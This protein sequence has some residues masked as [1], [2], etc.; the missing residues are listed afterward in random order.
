MLVSDRPLGMGARGSTPD[1]STEGWSDL[2]SLLT[3]HHFIGL[4]HVPQAKKAPNII[5]SPRKGGF[6]T[7]NLSALFLALHSPF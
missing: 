5:A 4:T 3:I 2:P 6:P 7:P 1:I